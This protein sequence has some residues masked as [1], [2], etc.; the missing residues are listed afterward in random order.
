LERLRVCDFFLLR[1]AQRRIE[2]L[3]QFVK[4]F[5]EVVELANLAAGIG[6]EVVEYLVFLAM[7]KPTSE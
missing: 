2:R 7:S 5:F 3:S 6:R 1:R 4:S